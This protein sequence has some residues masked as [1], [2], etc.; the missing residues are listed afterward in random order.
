M[1]GLENEREND[2]CSREI[3]QESMEVLQEARDDSEMSRRGLE[4]LLE[5]LVKVEGPKLMILL[6]EGFLV[7]ELEQRSLVTLAGR[8]AR[9]STSWLSICVQADV[10][11]NTRQPN[12]AQDRRL[13]VQSLEGLAAMS[14]GSLFRIAG[15]GEPTFDRLASEISAYTSLAWSNNRVT[16]PAIATGSMSRSVGAT[17]PSGRARRS[18]CHQ[19]ALRAVRARTRGGVARDAVVALRRIRLPLLATT[20]AQ[21]DPESGKV[22]SSWRRRSVSPVQSQATITSASS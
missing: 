2:R 7:D 3:D 14:R 6:S 9:R 20:F 22:D 8:R 10:T 18:C 17:S 19:R 1:P 4:Q 11:V 15:S 12:T 5:E 13:N 16:A 21:Q